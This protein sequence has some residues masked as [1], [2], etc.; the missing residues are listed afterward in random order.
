M[1][2]RIQ[3][4]FGLAKTTTTST[5]CRSLS[6]VVD[7]TLGLNQDQLEIQ[8]LAKDFAKNELFPVA[9]QCDQ[10]EQLPLDKL[11][12][13]GD[14]G[15]GAIYCSEEHGGTGLSR[16]DASLIFE[17]L[18]MAD[19]STA[20]YISIHN[21]VA[22][23]IDTYGSD[24]IK[25]KYLPKMASFEWLGSYCLTEPDS[26]SDAAALKTN[27]KIDGD[28]YV[29]NGSKAF[30][31]GSGDSKVYL[32]MLRHHGQPGPKGIFCLLVENDRPG[33]S[34]GKKERK[35]GWNTQ[36]TRII[37]FEDCRVPISNRIGGEN[38]G[39]NIAM[40]GLNGGR[41]NIASCSLGAAQASFDAA[42][43][44]VQIR[45]QFNQ[46]IGDFQWT[47]FK[48]A[49]MATKLVSSRLLIRNAADHLTRKTP[50]AASLCAM[51]KLHGTDEC[52]NVVNQ[53]LQMF[54]GY[55][56]LKDYP[57]E[58][59]L[60]DCRVHQIIEGTNEVM[61]MILGRDVLTK[62]KYS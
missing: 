39:F 7:P 24:E 2:R 57:I 16:F 18:S 59:H 53:A 10:Q 61:R 33:F 14:V 50:H 52:F 41:V 6:Y 20:A 44:H 43:D 22:A 62:E 36:P 4:L 11:K 47:Q 49:E 30:I 34:V 45:K 37:T 58:K 21:M 35:L 27:A 5:G 9:E 40:A 60:R 1:I 42:I 55:G 8:K 32:V 15:F 31:S 26:G 38:Q 17:Q 48:L 13:A 54:G 28:H 3:P 23:M 29:I 19:A 12:K 51:A 46:P 25:A 56:V